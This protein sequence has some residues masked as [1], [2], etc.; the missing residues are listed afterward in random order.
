[1]YEVPPCPACYLGKSEAH[2]IVC[3]TCKKEKLPMPDGRW[4]GDWWYCSLLCAQTPK[5]RGEWCREHREALEKLRVEH[6]DLFRV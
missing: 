5:P 3:V 2:V 4:E 1:M 6:P